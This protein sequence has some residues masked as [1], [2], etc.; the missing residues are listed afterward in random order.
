[1]DNAAFSHHGEEEDDTDESNVKGESNYNND[2]DVERERAI[3]K[4][5]TST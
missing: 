2:N 4:H 5:V 3:A 1:M